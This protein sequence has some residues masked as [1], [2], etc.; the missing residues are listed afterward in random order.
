M[1]HSIP[2]KRTC[3]ILALEFSQAAALAVHRLRSEIYR[4]TGSPA[5][6]AFPPI[7]PICSTE[8]RP[9]KQDMPKVPS[10]FSETPSLYPTFRDL[11]TDQC[12]SLFL[13]PDT[14]SLTLLT[15]VLQALVQWEVCDVSRSRL[16]SVCGIESL[17]F[18]DESQELFPY[19]GIF[20]STQVSLRDSDP[21]IIELARQIPP[22]K[23]LTLICFEVTMSEDRAWWSRLQYGELWRVHLR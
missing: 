9:I 8:I 14:T 10:P 17:F 4:K 15:P 11:T 23:D 3:W 2:M 20:L 22:L 6:R 1:R 18:H 19:P 16:H 7:I 13:T 5:A 21:A 12:G